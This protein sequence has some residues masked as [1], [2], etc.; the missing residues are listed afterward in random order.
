MERGRGRGRVRE[1]AGK[2]LTSR[3]TFVA[4]NIADGATAYHLFSMVPNY[5]DLELNKIAVSA[6]E[7]FGIL[8]GLLLVKGV[9][10]PAVLGM[11]AGLTKWDSYSAR[12]AHKKGE[13]YK[14]G[15][16]PAFFMGLANIGF[17]LGALSNV[18]TTM[19]YLSLPVAN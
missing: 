19:W 1:V 18:L 5:G 3:G 2:V 9:L 14:E 6:T 10:V 12:E 4:A 15:Q 16:G 11:H 8:G 13:K 7:H 17:S